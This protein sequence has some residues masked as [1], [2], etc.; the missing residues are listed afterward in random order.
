MSEFSFVLE[1]FPEPPK[2]N[3]NYNVLLKASFIYKLQLDLGWIKLHVNVV[4]YSHAYIIYSIKNTGKGMTF[5]AVNLLT[6]Y[7]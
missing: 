6:S 5:A 1:T 2:C 4:N 7:L 3:C